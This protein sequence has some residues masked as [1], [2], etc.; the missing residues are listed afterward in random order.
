M[1]RARKV[2]QSL[3][4]A[5]PGVFPVRINWAVIQSCKQKRDESVADLQICLKEIFRQHSGLGNS[6]A[7]LAL[8][9]R[10]IH[11]LGSELVIY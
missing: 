11:G 8:S 10:F 2:G 9:A 4:E 7:N 1:K 5:L 6:E 3:L